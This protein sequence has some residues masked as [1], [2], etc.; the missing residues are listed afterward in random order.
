M[1]VTVCSF[2][3]KFGIPSTADLVFDV[4]FL[5]NPYYIAELKECTGLD[6][7]VRDFLNSYHQTKDYLARLEDLLAFTLPLYEEEGKTNLVIALGCTGGRHRSVAMAE[8]VGDFVSKRGYA[9][10]IRHPALREQTG[11]EQT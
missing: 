9:T 1:S 7:E 8:A 4:R 5:P 10:V 6:R 2:G 11:E 3:Y